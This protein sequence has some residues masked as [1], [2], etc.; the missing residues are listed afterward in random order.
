MRK[1]W[2]QEPHAQ[3]VPPPRQDLSLFL[4]RG[5]VEAQTL[6][7]KP[8]L[9]VALEGAPAH[10]PCRWHG[11][12]QVTLRV[13]EFTGLVACNRAE[14]IEVKDHHDPGLLHELTWIGS[15][16]LGWDPNNGFVIKRS[17]IPASVKVREL[18]R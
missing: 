15:E 3:P 14:G 16:P 7:S 10:V 12:T 2:H 8:I 17:R 4:W 13:A 6:G 1:P 11:V 18:A 9:R 5:R